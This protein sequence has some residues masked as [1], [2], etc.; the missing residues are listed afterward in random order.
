MVVMPSHN[1][2]VMSGKVGHKFIGFLVKDLRV[3]RYRRWN[4]EQFIIF[5]MVILQK[6]RHVTASQA[7]QRRTDK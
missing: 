5:Q 1:G 3:V 4:F 6:A 2:D 7:I